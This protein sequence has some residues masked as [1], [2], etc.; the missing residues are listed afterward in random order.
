MKSKTLP[1]AVLVSSLAVQGAEIEITSLTTNGRLSWT[2]SFTNGLFSVEWAA[3]LPGTWRDNWGALQG[4]LVSNQSNTVEV[5]MFYR[6]KCAT[7]LFEV[8]PLGGRSVFAA[9]N[10]TGAVWTVQGTILGYVTPSVASGQEYAVAEFI[11][12]GRMS[13]S[14]V[15][16]TD[17]ERI[18]VD[19]DTLAEV[20]GGVQR[21]PIGTTW[22]NFNYKG[23][24]TRVC[25]VEANETVT[26]PA[27]TFQ[28]LK[29]SRRILEPL[30]PPVPQPFYYEWV[31]P[32]FGVVKMIDYWQD[33]SQQPP[34]VYEL[35]S[36]SVP[37]P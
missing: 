1:L 5:P 37:T 35:Q 25:T 26:V 8:F 17:S 15:R 3:S 31:K 19:A 28:C 27:G 22:T 21:A 29:F 34:V 12:R 36:R 24:Y 6:L 20:N 33:A 2:N 14:L 30:N 9:S 13:L 32:G 11:D 10:V 23:R 18:I 4:F 7:N 16:S